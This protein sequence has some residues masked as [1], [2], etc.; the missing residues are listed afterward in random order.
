MKNTFTIKSLVAAGL[1]TLA[2]LAAA[3]L[4]VG[5]NPKS[6]LASMTAEQVSAIFRGK[7]NTLPSGATAAPVDLP[8]SSAVLEQFY[9]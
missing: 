1:I 5:V 4:V 6:P 9:S 2:N 3:E 8:E 7:T